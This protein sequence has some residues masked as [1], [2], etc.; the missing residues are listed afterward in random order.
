MA[1]PT[2]TIRVLSLIP[3]FWPRQGGAQMVLA[4][5]A[6]GLGA[7]I[8]CTVLTRGYADSPR[9]E[10]MPSLKV[11]RYPNPAPEAWKD[12]ATGAKRVS[13][14][15]K[16][17]VGLFDVLGSAARLP[18]LARNAD[19]VHLHFPLPLGLAAL[20][21]RKATHKPLVVTVHGNADIYELPKSM[22]PLTRAV[23][24]S[25]DAV[26]S[27][28][29]DLA[30]YLRTNVGV[31][32][33]IA[34]PNGVDTKLFSPAAHTPGE[35]LTLVSI[36]RI[37]PR[38]NID[39]LIAA[40]RTLAERGENGLEL[41]I[42]GTGP[43]EAQVASLAAAA[44][45]TTF[46]GFIDEAKKRELLARADVFVQLSIR[47]GL[48][49]ATLEAMA[50]GIPCVVSDLPGVREPVTPGETGFLVP[51]PESVDSVVATLTRLIE[52]RGELLRMRA[53]ARRSVEERYSV[54]AMAEGYFRVYER[55]LGGNAS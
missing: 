31:R 11:H 19:L 52:S 26:V 28:S 10:D 37:V 42:A 47:E 33:V 1:N 38:K 44:P 2:R 36:S 12:Y 4:E 16:L 3:T 45:N 27:V 32:N 51:N 9:D 23:L 49:I 29:E 17:C 5:I 46:L 7:R 22:A 41:L 15:S 55:V 13:F 30:D 24:H 39:V 20:A 18:A 34:V 50:C 8:D 14:P 21:W 53:A 48:S 54:Q 35:K 43:A 6:H 40:V 25:A